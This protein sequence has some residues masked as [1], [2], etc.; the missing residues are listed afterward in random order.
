[1][2]EQESNRNNDAT[3]YKLAEA[4][5]KGQMAKSSDVV[6]VVVYLVA[7]VYLYWHGQKSVQNQ[8]QLCQYIFQ[9]LRYGESIPLEQF[10][11]SVIL[12]CLELLLPFFVVLMIA[13][14]VANLMQTGP[15]FTTHPLQPDFSK[16]NPANGI[17]KIFSWKTL[18]EAFR[19]LLKLLVLGL[20]LYMSLKNLLPKFFLMSWLSSISF[21]Q[22]LTETLASFG[23]KM[24]V[25]LALIAAIDLLFMRRLFFKQ[26]MM[27][28]RELKDEHKHREGDPRI[29]SR[30]RQLRMELRK[31]TTS[32]AKT[33]S[34][35]VVI[36]NPTHIAV[37]LKYEHGKMDSPQLIAK[38]AGSAAL[39][40]RIIARKNHIPVVENR[41]L[42]RHL[43]KRVDF[44]GFVPSDLYA[45][46]ARIVVW[47]FAAKR[48]M[49]QEQRV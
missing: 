4:K 16:L 26:M 40:M 32:I 22:L 35:D 9:N 38:G 43:F 11:F 7:V 6:S 33:S 15:I 41:P 3:P 2:S 39:M 17:K 10:T 37:A 46:V 25:V 29:R 20:V 49:L 47:V 24:G 31:R 36:A 19:S 34:A 8:F 48:A 13:A 42:A 1:M 12:H 27:S 45:D 30:M 44:D 23:L 21:L 14:V 18:F 28:Q 5:K